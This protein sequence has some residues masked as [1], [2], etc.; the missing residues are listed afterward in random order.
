MKPILCLFALFAGLFIASQAL[1]G[2]LLRLLIRMR[3][4][5][6]TANSLSPKPLRFLLILISLL[7]GYEISMNLGVLISLQIQKPLH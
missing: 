1:W 2:K 3:W 7:I 4:S 5:L 6:I